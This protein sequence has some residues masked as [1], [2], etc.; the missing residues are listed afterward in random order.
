MLGRLLVRLGHLLGRL[1]GLLLNGLVGLLVRALD[2]G[3]R[4]VVIV[5][6]AAA[7]ERQ[8][9]RSHARPGRSAPH[10]ATAD[11]PRSHSTPVVRCAHPSSCSCE[12]LIVSNPEA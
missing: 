7:N 4:T 9:R 2:L 6:I 1:V 10:R 8:P 3:D 12:S 5:I 11:P